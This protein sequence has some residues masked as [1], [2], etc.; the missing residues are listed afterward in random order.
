MANPEGAKLLGGMLEKMQ[1]SNQN[2]DDD[3]PQKGMKAMAS[4]IDPAAAQ[5]MMMGFTVKRMLG[6]GSVP[7]E[8]VLA[9]NQMLNQIKK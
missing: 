5:K 3:D 2:P 7:K 6:F 1:Q 4:K 9:I 8:Q